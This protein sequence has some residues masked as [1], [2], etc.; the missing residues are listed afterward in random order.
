MHGGE[1]TTRTRINVRDIQQVAGL[2]ANLSAAG[3]AQPAGPPSATASETVTEAGEAVAPV[4]DVR[5][6]AA[7]WMDR[8]GLLS[9]YGNYQGAARSYQKALELAPELPEAHFQK[10]VAYGELGHFDAAIDAIS[11]AIDRM[12]TNGTYF[13]GRARVYLLA[14]DE[15]LAMKDFMEAG[16]LGNEDARSYLKHAGVDWN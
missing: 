2:F 3:N 16:F 15:E 12:P 4:P 7:Y 13:Y 8:G 9:A 10:G 1:L 5:D 6:T 14:G 11:R